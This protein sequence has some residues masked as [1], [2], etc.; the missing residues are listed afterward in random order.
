MKMQI[1]CN[2]CDHKW[3]E[4]VYYKHA[5]DGRRC[6][7]CKD[8]NLK[9]REFI[10]VVIDT[11]VDCKPFETKTSSEPVDKVLPSMGDYD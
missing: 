10:S 2:Y 9:I 8:K 4:N 3:I 1:T 11:Y 6:S 5:M 7:V